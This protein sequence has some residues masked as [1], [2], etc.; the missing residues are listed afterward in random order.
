MTETIFK[1]ATVTAQ[2]V[3]AAMQAFDATYPDTNDYDNWLDKAT[4]KYAVSREGRL[5][6]PK[7]ILSEATGISTAD[8]SGGEQTN[9]V[10]EQLGFEVIKLWLKRAPAFVEGTVYRRSALHQ[11]FGGQQQGGISTP[12]QYD[13]IMLFT[14]ETG[15]QYGYSDGWSDDG[16]F[17]YTGEG[18]TGDMTFV[19][20]N[21]AIRDHLEDEKDL[22]LFAYV[23]TGYVRYE[24]QMVATGYQFRRAPDQH[25]N[26]REVI[27][28]ELVPVEV[29]SER[30]EAVEAELPADERAPVLSTAELRERA[31]ATAARTA[32]PVERKNVYRK[33]SYWIKEYALR[34]AGGTCEGCGMPAPFH[35]DSDKPYLEVHHIRR[36][37]D[38]GPDHPEAVIALC[39][40]CHRRAH[41]SSDAAVF[42]AHLERTARELED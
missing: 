8:F 37:A 38:G 40:N 41:Y 36:L 17:L 35:T 27:V 1:N 15:E 33:R 32:T 6:P 16:V 18:Q 29:M 22:H 28:F 19:R 26:D 2:D 39:P 31:L 42:N 5:Y 20:G 34:R 7:H 25:G 13:M 23:S 4:Y 12:S 9:R 3:S 24:G 10:F 30:D 11:Q 14:G 21:R